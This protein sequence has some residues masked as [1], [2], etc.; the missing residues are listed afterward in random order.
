[1]SLAPEHALS[2]HDRLFDGTPWIT[3]DGRVDETARFRVVEC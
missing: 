2:G 3:D 1:M